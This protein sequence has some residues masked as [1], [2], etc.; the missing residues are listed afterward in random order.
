M[1][2]LI[3]KKLVWDENYISKSHKYNGPQN[4][5]SQESLEGKWN[6]GRAFW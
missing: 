5:R 2:F 4:G 3:Y 1:A 6:E